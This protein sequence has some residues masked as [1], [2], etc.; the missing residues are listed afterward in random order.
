VAAG[1]GARDRLMAT[2]GGRA[3]LEPATPSPRFRR[4][5]AWYSRRLFR[6]KFGAVRLSRESM[7]AFSAAASHDGPVLFALNHT[8]WWDPLLG[9]VLTEGFLA[10]RPAWVPMELEQLRKFAFMKRLGIFGIDPDRADAMDLLVSHAVELIGANPRAVFG[11]T[12]QG[13]FADVRAPIRLRPG[14]AAIVAACPGMLVLTVACEYT[15]WHE[16]K[17]DV[18]VHA[19]IGEPPEPRTTPAWHRAITRAMRENQRRLADLVMTRDGQQ[20][21]VWLGGGRAGA[22]PVYDALQRARGADAT[23]SPT[24]RRDR[25]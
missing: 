7:E 21:D 15:F 20:F 17:P 3:G 13:T 1:A 4:F 19:R 18:F 9:L 5:F 14:A 23:I 25:R 10:D 16:Q 12:P 24:E 11:I 8:S 2:R 22:H 6:K